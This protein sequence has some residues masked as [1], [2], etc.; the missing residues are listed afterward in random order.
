[1]WTTKSV[2]SSQCAT[3]VGTHLVLADSE[4]H[5][6]SCRAVCK[7]WVVSSDQWALHDVPTSSPYGSCHFMSISQA[8]LRLE[9]L[10]GE[11]GENG[12]HSVVNSWLSIL[13]LCMRFPHVFC[14]PGVR[15]V[16]M[17]GIAF[18]SWLALVNSWYGVFAS[19]TEGALGSVCLQPVHTCFAGFF[20]CD[21]PT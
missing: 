5:H 11:T 14:F 17:L 1:M 13:G 6:A 16:W 2:A 3:T 18:P 19:V 12:N 15:G 20:L 9:L 10:S 4:E 8:A 21:S 7:G